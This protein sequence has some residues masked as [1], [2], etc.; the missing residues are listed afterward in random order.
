MIQA[1]TSR[2]PQKTPR[3]Q[4]DKKRQDSNQEVRNASI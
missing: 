2:R 1:K 4:A 3:N